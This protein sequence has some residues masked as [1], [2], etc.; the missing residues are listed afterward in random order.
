MVETTVLEGMLW[1]GC[2]LGLSL[3]FSPIGYPFGHL[4]HVGRHQDFLGLSSTFPNGSL[5]HSGHQPNGQRITGLV[6]DAGQV[7]SKNGGFPS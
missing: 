6:C 1:L 5:G 7:D 4:L 2:F 3:F